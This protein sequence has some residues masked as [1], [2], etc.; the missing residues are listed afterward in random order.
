MLPYISIE[1]D[2][3]GRFQDSKKKG[4]KKFSKVLFL[5]DMQTCQRIYI[6]S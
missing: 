5:L 3:L 4:V 2:M 1:Q 6:Y